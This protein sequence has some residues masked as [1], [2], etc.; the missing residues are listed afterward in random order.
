MVDPAVNEIARMQMDQ[1][2]HGRQ[3]SFKICI[4][5]FFVM[6]V[7]SIISAIARSLWSKYFSSGDWTIRVLKL[8]WTVPNRTLLVTRDLS[9]IPLNSFLQPRFFIK[10]NY[11]HC[12]IRGRSFLVRKRLWMW[13]LPGSD[14]FLLS[15]SSKLNRIQPI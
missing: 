9:A 5:V 10:I 12:I 1:L 13:L 6:L 14:P 11:Y 3:R 8:N 7:S 15:T 4:I 2:Q